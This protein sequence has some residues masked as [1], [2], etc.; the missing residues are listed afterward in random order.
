VGK[1]GIKKIIICKMEDIICNEIL[2]HFDDIKD[3]INILIINN[4]YYKIINKYIPKYI[5]DFI[6]KKNNLIKDL[7]TEQELWK[8]YDA[9]HNVNVNR[10]YYKTVFYSNKEKYYFNKLLDFYGKENVEFINK[11]VLRDIIN[12]TTIMMAEKQPPIEN[13]CNIP[14]YNGD[15]FVKCYGGDISWQDDRNHKYDSKFWHNGRFN[16]GYNKITKKYEK[17]HEDDI[18]HFFKNTKIIKLKQIANNMKKKDFNEKIEKLFII[19][20]YELIRE[21]EIN[22]KIY[23]HKYKY[24]KSKTGYSYKNFSPYKKTKLMVHS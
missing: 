22:K 19:Y 17:I 5:Y 6:I 18:I 4:N 11:F 8:G 1:Y 12:M 20:V 14:W 15:D 2:Y 3:I 24:N 7:N 21:C 10:K 16:N 9:H 13:G 23:W